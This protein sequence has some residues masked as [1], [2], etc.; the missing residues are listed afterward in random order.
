MSLTKV[1]IP[2]NM[3]GIAKVLIPLGIGSIVKC[4]FKKAMG[5][6]GWRKGQREDRIPGK[7]R[8]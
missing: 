5:I 8:A 6:G 7:Y 4:F 3:E 1:L 2:L